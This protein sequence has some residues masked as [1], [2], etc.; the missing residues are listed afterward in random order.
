MVTLRAFVTR[1]V[2]PEALDLISEA[3]QLEVWPGEYPPT[4][5]ELA[6]KAANADGLLTNIMVCFDASLLAH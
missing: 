2:F 4:P 3:A 6:S 5:E 1:R